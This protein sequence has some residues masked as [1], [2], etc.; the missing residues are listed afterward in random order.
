[1]TQQ[2]NALY[3]GENKEIYPILQKIKPEW[4]FLPQANSIEEVIEGLTT[5]RISNDIQALFILDKFYDRVGADTSFEDFIA[6]MGP[7]SVLGILNYRSQLKNQMIESIQ[8]ASYRSGGG[9]PR[10]YFISKNDPVNTINKGISDFI[11]TADTEPLIAVR[12]RLL[13][14]SPAQAQEEPEQI[15]SASADTFNYDDETEEPSEYMGNIIT[16]T[17]SKGGSGKSTVALTLATLLAHASVNSVREG[18]EERPLKVVIVDLDVR[19]GQIGFITGF[20]SPTVLNLRVKG[21]ND[22]TLEDTI[23][24]SPRLKVDILLAPKKPRAS[25]D[26]P[27]DFYLELLQHLKR[28]YDYIILD[29]SV[30]YL[31][32]LLENVAYPIANKIIFVTDIVINSIFSM[33]RWVQEVINPKEKNGM[34]IDGRKIGIVVNKSLAHINMSGDKIA[35]SALG[36]PII[37]AIPSSP[38]FIAHAANLMSMETILKHGDLHNSFDRLARAIVG[39]SYKLSHNVTP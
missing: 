10:Y 27:P 23:I 12:D 3:I 38:K 28:K 2:V 7:H 39:R 4:N 21:I 11:N 31:D 18:L 13:G 17:S 20:N 9:Q 32:P 33:T 24:H 5:G 34:G 16:V 8:E 15:S 26:T 29:T 37:T 22:E 35:K 14:R 19:D 36:L 1:M 30:N 25:E 6:F